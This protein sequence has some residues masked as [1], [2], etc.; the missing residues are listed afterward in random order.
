MAELRA[1]SQPYGQWPTEFLKRNNWHF[2]DHTGYLLL[3]LGLSSDIFFQ[4]L[5]TNEN[6][7]SSGVPC[8]SVSLRP[9]KELL[10]LS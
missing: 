8:L 1:V 10:Q 5:P 6:N 3:P 7:T 2:E 4:M 9:L